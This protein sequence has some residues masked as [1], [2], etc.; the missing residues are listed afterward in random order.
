LQVA[1]LAG[2]PRA[3]IERARHKLV[4]L[5]NNAVHAHEPA[6]QL[7]LFDAAPPHP[8]VRAVAETDPDAMT[9]R[10][11]LALLYRLRALL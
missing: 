1:A 7:G 2:V 9:P 8:L 5:E 6:R 11:A 4:E 10:D 3:V